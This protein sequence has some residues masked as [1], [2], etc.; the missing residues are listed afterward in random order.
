MMKTVKFEKGI[1]FESNTTYVAT[2]KRYDF[3]WN[4]IPEVEEKEAYSSCKLASDHS[5]IAFRLIGLENVVLDFGGAELMFH[6]RVAPFVLKRC[7]NITLKNFKIDYD[8]PFYTQ[9]EVLSVADGVMEVKVCDGFDYYVKDNDLHVIGDGWDKNLNAP[10]QLLWMYDKTRTKQYPFI[11]GC[12]GDVIYPMENPAVPIRHIKVEKKGD[13]LLLKGPFPQQWD[14]N[15]GNNLL[16]ITHELR[17]KHT[18]A[19]VSCE[20]VHFENITIIH[21]PSLVLVGYGSTNIEVD[22]L[23]LYKNYNGNGRY[24]TSNADSILTF[25]CGGDITVRN[26]HLEGM[27]DDALNFHGNYLRI[28]EAVGNQLT[29]RFP[30]QGRTIHCPMVYDGQTIAVYRQQ[31]IEKKAQYQVLQVI[32]DEAE[33]CYRLKVDGDVSELCVGDFVENLSAQPKVLVEDCFI[34]EYRGIMR[35]SNREKTV[36]QNCIFDNVGS[37]I[38]LHGDTTYWYESGPVEDLTIRNCRFLHSNRLVLNAMGEVQFTEKEPYF[39]KNITVENCSFEGCGSQGAVIAR[40]NHV[41]NV[42]F[43]N[44]KSDG[45]TQIRAVASGSIEAEGITVIRDQV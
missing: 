37:C 21:S 19:Y 9:M 30:G 24:V 43:R 27:M 29:L 45:P 15:D 20:N 2:E 34:G 32:Q 42:V 12:I 1:A 17:D 25:N 36:L 5:R 10:C 16:I 28:D 41:D 4:E 22:G 7:K 26:C 18:V 8:R 38:L 14:T 40:L 23:R 44:N 13:R 33:N 6:G 35:F 39:H 11:Q 31:T 3:Y